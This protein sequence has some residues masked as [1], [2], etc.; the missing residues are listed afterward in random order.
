MKSWKVNLVFYRLLNVGLSMK[1]TKDGVELLS[2]SSLQS[3]APD[4]GWFLD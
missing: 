2:F 3:F 1:P 4:W